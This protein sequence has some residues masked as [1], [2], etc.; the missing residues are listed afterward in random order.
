MQRANGDGM[1]SLTHTTCNMRSQA[2]V[3]DVC[4][5]RDELEN[6]LIC[7]SE[8]VCTTLHALQLPHHAPQRV[9]LHLPAAE[10]AAVITAC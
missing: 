1:P 8:R 5:L 7:S 4:K 2:P 10:A 9:Q 3:P 6:H